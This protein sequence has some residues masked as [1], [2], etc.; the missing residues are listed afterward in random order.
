M[1]GILYPSYLGSSRVR[2]MSESCLI[3]SAASDPSIVSTCTIRKATMRHARE[4]FGYS[5]LETITVAIL[6]GPKP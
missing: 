4:I 5:M 6:T 3:S 2:E 1:S